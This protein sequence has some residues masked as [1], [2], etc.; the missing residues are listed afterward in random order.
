MEPTPLDNKEGDESDIKRKHWFTIQ[1]DAVEAFREMVGLSQRAWEKKLPHLWCLICSRHHR[2]GARTHPCGT[3]AWKYCDEKPN[4]H[5]SAGVKNH[6]CPIELFPC[7]NSL[8][9]KWICMYRQSWY[10]VRKITTCHKRTRTYGICQGHHWCIA[11]SR[12]PAAPWLTEATAAD[13]LKFDP[14]TVAAKPL[15][16]NSITT[17][18][19]AAIHQRQHGNHLCVCV[20][21]RDVCAQSMTYCAIVAPRIPESVAHCV[22]PLR[23]HLSPWNSV[24]LLTA[25]VRLETNLWRE[26]VCHP[27]NTSKWRVAC[28][29]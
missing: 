7:S 25:A 12:W 21:V 18:S 27:I 9:W 29:F 16:W 17:A 5:S 28:M 13:M 24:A 1:D 2:P 26:S 10:L 15:E 6:K 22:A 20:R 8:K 19:K 23:R 4:A 14:A 11:E 3:L